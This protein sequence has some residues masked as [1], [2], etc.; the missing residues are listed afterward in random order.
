MNAVRIMHNWTLKQFN[1]DEI[2]VS[3]WSL[4]NIFFD[5]EAF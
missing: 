2:F 5:F 1:N 3:S 4:S